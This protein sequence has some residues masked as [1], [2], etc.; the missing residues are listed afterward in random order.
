MAGRGVRLTYAAVR[1]RCR[2]CGQVWARTLRRRR[3]SA[4]DTGHPGAGLLTAGGQCR[5][6][7][8]AVGRDGH[9]LD[10]GATSARRDCR[11]KVLPQAAAGPHVRAPGGHHAE[12]ASSGGAKAGGVARRRTP[13]APY[14]D[15]RV[16]NSHRPTREHERRMHRF[17][18]TG[19]AQGLLPACGPIASHF[20]PRLHLRPAPECRREMAQRFKPWL[21]KRRVRCR[22]PAAV[23]GGYLR[24][25]SHENS[26]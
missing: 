23:P 22:P 9:A 12:P 1:Y 11:D 8:P 5:C 14:L 25:S 16:A 13:A 4:G 24:M 19:K 15:R 6:L 20:R 17:K 2:Q 3:P 10:P 21:H 7:W 26:R 18:P